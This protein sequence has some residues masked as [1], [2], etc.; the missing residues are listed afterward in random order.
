MS[1]STNGSIRTVLALAECSQQSMNLGSRCKTL[2]K[3]DRFASSG[4]FRTVHFFDNALSRRRTLF[5][6]HCKGHFAITPKL[7]SSSS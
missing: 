2:R 4:F 3:L 1:A 6:L 7:N 5:V